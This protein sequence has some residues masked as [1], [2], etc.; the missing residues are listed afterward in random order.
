MRRDRDNSTLGAI[1]ML[2][3]T[4]TF[5]VMWVFVKQ[6]TEQGVHFVEVMLF[7]NLVAVFPMLLFVMRAGG[8]GLL[9]SAYPAR[10]LLR[11]ATGLGAMGTN[12]FALSVL[13]IADTTALLYGTPIFA[14]LLSIPLLGERVGPWRWAAVIVGFCGI[15]WIAA[16]QGAFGGA[17]AAGMLATIATIA[18]M[19]H[20]IFSGLTQLLVRQLSATDHTASIVFW[21]S[22]LMALL[23]A[24]VVPFVWSGNVWAAFWP[25]LAVGLIGS[26][27]QF[28]LTE[29]YATAE[30]SALGVYS[31]ASI[32]WATLLGWLIWGD[33]PALGFFG[34]AALIVASGL[35]I[36]HRERLRRAQRLTRDIKA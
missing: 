18:G 36:L 22:V 32:L 3:S 2:G 31:Y 23:V 29:A 35:V 33:V 1:F 6:A 11:A 4:L 27:G 8:F 21:Q 7:R 17:H 19:S 9:R 24:L 10:H 5:S 30:A 28:L 20:G 14:T 13:P 26:V 15:L 34:G 16:S 25:L 12:F